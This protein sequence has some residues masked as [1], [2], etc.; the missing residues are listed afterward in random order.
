MNEINRT[1]QIFTKRERKF[2]DKEEREK[3]LNQCIVISTI[4]LYITIIVMTIIQYKGKI[5]DNPIIVAVYALIVINIGI[6][7]FMLIKMPMYEKIKHISTICF[8]AI[9]S[10]LLISENSYYLLY[11]TIIIFLV[12]ILYFRERIMAVYAIISI[13]PV[14]INVVRFAIPAEDIAL[15]AQSYLYIVTVVMLVRCTAIGH[16]FNHDALHA[17]QDEQQ[18][19]KVML[20]EVLHIAEAV[21][22][23]AIESDQLVVK[24]SD[25]IGVVGS[26]VKEISSSTQVTADSIQEQT[27]MT[28]T[29]QESI[30]ETVELSKKM[31]QVANESGE[32]VSENL[33]KM[34]QL[35]EHANKVAKTNEVVA[36]SMDELHTKTQQVKDITSMIF[37]ISSQTNLLALNAS[38]ESARAGEAGRGFAVV[39]DQIRQL[40]EQTREA[41]ENI[42]KIIEELN[43]EATNALI[44]VK[45]NIEVSNEQGTLITDTS[46]SFE[47]VNENMKMLSKDIS[48]V[49]T[50]LEELSTSNQ[51]IVDNISQLS[52][53]SEE[54]FAS[55]QQ[56]EEVSEVSK[57]DSSNARELLEQ[58]IET[59]KGLDKYLEK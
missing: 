59:A 37:S 31:V 19:Q 8:L 40:A 14:V 10:I 32:V 45:E 49:D 39:A 22:V 33:Y 28:N 27:V 30:T 46:T 15:I 3:V 34:T 29:I 13:I 51:V 57:E 44:T 9:Y 20:D 23:G 2:K 6:D 1:Q 41:T 21:K 50:K 55:A 5:A 42:S 56:G 53:A 16:L 47:K 43:N 52:A 12:L 48:N 4:I 7:I 17:I 38:I 24:L 58:L 26:A 54:V 18:A 35:Q 11:A 36:K 25:S